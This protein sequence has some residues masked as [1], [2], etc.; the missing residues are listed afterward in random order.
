MK[1]SLTSGGPY[2]LVKTVVGTAYTDS[3]LTSGR[4]YYYVV[5]ATNAS[6]ESPPSAEVSAQAK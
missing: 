5:T 4:T 3:K 2:L 6:G 1:R